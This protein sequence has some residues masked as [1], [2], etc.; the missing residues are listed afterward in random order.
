MYAPKNHKQ[1][2]HREKSTW[3]G[4]RNRISFPSIEFGIKNNRIQ[5]L[6]YKAKPIQFPFLFEI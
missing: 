5:E 6:N 4:R 2:Q 1:K 3:G